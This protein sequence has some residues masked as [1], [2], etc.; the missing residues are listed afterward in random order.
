[1]RTMKNHIWHPYTKHSEVETGLLH[2][3]KSE[4]IYLIDQN[5]DKYV[6]AVSSWWS[7]ALGHSYPRL[8][9]ALKKQA[10]Q[11]QHTILGHITHPKALSVAQKLAQLMPSPDRH[12]HFASDG[13]CAIEA[14][15][16]IALQ[17]WAN[18]NLT[19]KKYFA[20]LREGYHGDTL[21]AVSVGYIETFHKPFKEMLPGTLRLPVPPYDGA[22][23]QCI[24]IAEHE[25]TRQRDQLAALIVEPLCQGSAGMRIYSKQYLKRLAE[26]CSKNNILLIVDEIATGFGR[27]G[28]MFAF[29]HAEIDPDIV[30]VGKALSGGYLPISGAIV[31]DSIYNTFSDIPKDQTFYHGHTFAG[32]PLSAAVADEA[33]DIYHEIEIATLAART[34]QA[35]ES[36]LKTL[37]G[38]P[39]VKEIRCLGMI[40]AVE[41]HQNQHIKGKKIANSIKIKMLEKGYLIRP[42]GNILYLMMP[43]IAT[44]EEVEA[45][46]NQLVETI[47]EEA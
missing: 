23:E 4:G 3:E 24:E 22:Y 13:S 14:A 10:D 35:L 41:L 37:E 43:L 16:K 30:C 34:G 8:V 36:V 19:E 5:G 42:L 27:T 44:K 28:K 46:A 47:K 20:S 26:I 6:D 2:F 33:L 29:E 45:A 39:S 17:Y 40:G 9:K 15:M 38:H 31:K 7:C 18:S 11:L 25:L 1:M 32:N 12:V 21:N